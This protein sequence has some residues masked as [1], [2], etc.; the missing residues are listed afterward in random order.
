[1]KFFL[2]KII[3]FMLNGLKLWGIQSYIFHGPKG[4]HCLFFSRSCFWYCHCPHQLS[5]LRFHLTQLG[6]DKCIT[7]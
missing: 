5:L 7:G 1:M 4:A 2:A 6:Y 3:S